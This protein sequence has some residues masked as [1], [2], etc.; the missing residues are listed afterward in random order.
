M[1]I[2]W[3]DRCTCVHMP[4]GISFD[5][6]K[7]C[8]NKLNIEDGNNKGKGGVNDKTVA[9]W[10][11]M[12]NQSMTSHQ[13]H[14]FYS[15][16][17]PANG[18]SSS[19]IRPPFLRALPLPDISWLPFSFFFFFLSFFTKLSEEFLL[20]IRPLH[21][22][23]QPFHHEHDATE[24]HILYDVQLKWIQSFPSPMLVVLPGLKIP[25]RPSIYS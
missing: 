24:S 13:L 8:P 14:S 10:T 17:K 23:T 15:L 18:I 4:Q 25:I 19:A 1:N 9:P 5:V 21:L 2:C 3:L 12:L 7:T 11:A 6:D 16:N 22:F 20:P